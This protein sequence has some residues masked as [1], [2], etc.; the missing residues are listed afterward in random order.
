MAQQNFE[1][2]TKFVPM[3]HFVAVPIFLMNFIWAIRDLIVHF[4]AGTVR[5]LLVAFAL[6]VSCFLARIFAL[7]VQDRVIR[8]EMRMRLQ[9]LLPA[10]LRPRVGEFTLGQLVSLRFAGDA[11]LPVLARKV[12]DEKIADRKTIKKMIQSWQ[13]DLLRA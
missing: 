3:F 7:T 6:L 4:S 10:D 11:E 2:H 5:G 9:E 13:P 12:L 8:L 1:N